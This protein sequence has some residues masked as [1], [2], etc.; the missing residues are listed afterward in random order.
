MDLEKWKRNNVFQILEKV[1]LSPVEFGWDHSADL[2]LIHGP[3]KSYFAFSSVPYKKPLVFVAGDAV[4][5]ERTV[6]NWAEQMGKFEL[7]AREVKRY[8]EMPDLWAELGS[9]G[10]VLGAAAR[11][12]M[13]D[14]TP[15][16]PDE[17][18]EIT[19]QLRE[20]QD[21]LKRTHALSEDEQRVLDERFTY[22]E[23]AASRLGRFDWRNAL[24]GAFLGAIVAGILTPEVVRAAIAMIIDR[25]APLLFQTPPTLLGG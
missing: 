25:L 20:I 18:S 24:I 15:F 21:Y 13:Q 1:G 4:K 23:T 10:S 7:W 17:Q 14:N 16:T 3:T 8:Y 19:K 5:E 12:G 11:E 22:L 9:P 2:T 6:S